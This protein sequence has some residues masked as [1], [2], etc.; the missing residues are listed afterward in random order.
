MQ[1]FSNGRTGLQLYSTGELMLLHNTQGPV[2]TEY[3]LESLSS[4]T[5][6]LIFDMASIAMMPLMA[7]FVWLLA[8]NPSAEDLHDRSLSVVVV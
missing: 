5:T 2:Q 8:I 4:L 3:R 6:E 1:D 7:R